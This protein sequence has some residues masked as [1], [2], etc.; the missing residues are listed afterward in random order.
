MEAR[1]PGT[2]RINVV[3]DTPKG[4]QNK[5][6][7][8][9]ELGLFRLSRILPT[10]M[11]FPYDFGSVPRT[12]A[13]DGDAL[14][15]LLVMDAATFAGCVVTARLIGVMRATQTENRKTLRNDRLIAVAETPVNRPMIRRMEELGRDRLSEI[16]Q[17]FISY[18]GVHK[19]E[20]KPTGRLGPKAAEALLEKAMQEFGR[21]AAK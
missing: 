10:G 20:F 14:D 1:D 6:K 5:Y 2:K 15:V 9:E 3:V 19:R 11:H 8:D 17:F 7:Y 18:N 13:E 21:E 12:R 4:S 16:E